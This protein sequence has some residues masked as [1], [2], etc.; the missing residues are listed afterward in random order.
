MLH[1]AHPMQPLLTFFEDE[2][3]GAISSPPAKFDLAARRF[4]RA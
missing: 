3:L 1:V 4:E 2:L